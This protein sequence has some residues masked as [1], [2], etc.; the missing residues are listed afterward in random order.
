MTVP[1][2]LLRREKKTEHTMSELAAGGAEPALPCPL[3]SFTLA[4]FCSSFSHSRRSWCIRG[5]LQKLSFT[6]A[7]LLSAAALT[8]VCVEQEAN[9]ARQFKCEM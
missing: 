3:R 2:P 9:W 7:N 5:A 4:L 8:T 6:D 1:F